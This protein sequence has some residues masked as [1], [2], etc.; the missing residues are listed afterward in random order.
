MPL[1]KGRVGLKKF[2]LDL[3]DRPFTDRLS[4]SQISALADLLW[5]PVVVAASSSRLNFRTR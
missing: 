3:G 5:L 4:E 2:S 1:G